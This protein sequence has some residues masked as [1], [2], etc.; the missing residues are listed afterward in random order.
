MVDERNDTLLLGDIL[1]FICSKNFLRYMSLEVI[2][3]D[4]T[5]ICILLFAFVVAFAFL[6]SKSL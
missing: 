3:V 5:S 2:E 1:G 6:V 4:G